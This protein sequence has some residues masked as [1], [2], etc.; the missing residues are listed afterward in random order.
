MENKLPKQP[1]FARH[2]FVGN[3]SNGNE[4]ASKLHLVVQYPRTKEGGIVGKVLGTRETYT[5]LTRVLSLIEPFLKLTAEKGKHITTRISSEK[6]SLKKIYAHSRDK[7]MTYT[8]ADLNFKDITITERY[9]GNDGSKRC[10]VFFLTGPRSLWHVCASRVPSFTGEIE[11]EVHNSKI[12]LDEHFPFEI[13]VTPWYFYDKTPAPYN[14]QLTTNVLV[15][16]LQT[17]TSVKQLSNQNFVSLGRLLAEDLTLLVSFLSKHWV[18]WYRYE[19]QTTNTIETYIR[20]IRECPT[21]EPRNDDTPVEENKSREFLKIGFSNLRKL[22]ADRLDLSMPIVYYVSANEK[23][24]LEEQFTTFF[25][26]LERIKDLFALKEKLQKNLSGR[27][28]KELKTLVSD[29]IEKNIKP[30]EVSEKILNKIPELNR[31]ST[32]FVLDLLLSKYN[33]DWIDIYPPASAFTLIKTRNELFHSSR[34]L[35]IDLLTK[36]V[37]RLQSIIERLLLRMLGWEDISRTPTDYIKKWLTTVENDI[38][39]T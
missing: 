17:K 32:R 23:K 11:N 34:K 26:S 3:L 6:V 2:E 7:D 8:V 12:E 4:V 15:L 36:E 1:F 31:P 25:L 14:Y 22:R 21:E 9:K 5:K 19:L 13:E 37:Y 24:Y 29:I 28:F 27:D 39:D 16:N 30:R 38:N 33:I 18:K 20:S 10:L 35:N